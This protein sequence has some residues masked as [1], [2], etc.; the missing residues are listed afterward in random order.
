M[1]LATKEERIAFLKSGFTGKEIEELY[2]DLNCFEE[3]QVN[4]DG[5]ATN[6]THRRMETIPAFANHST[7]SVRVQAVPSLGVRA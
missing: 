4:W 6:R 3:L 7:E 1:I 5:P 2:I